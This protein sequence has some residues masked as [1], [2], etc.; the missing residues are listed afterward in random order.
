MNGKKFSDAMSELDEKYIHEA[1]QYQKKGKKSVWVRPVIAACLCIAFISIFFWKQSIVSTPESKHPIVTEEGITI[2]PLNVSLSS[3]VTADM[4]GFFLYQGRVY[5]Q[6]EWLTDSGNLVGDYLGTATGSIDEWTPQ[7]GYVDLAGSV[8][9]DFYS[10]KGFD[11]AFLLCMKYA[12]GQ[13]STYICN[14]GITL[15]Y[16]FE[17]FED[18]LHLSENCLSVTYETQESHNASKDEIH[19]LDLQGEERFKHFVRAINAAPFMRIQDIPLGEKETSIYDREIYRVYCNMQNG[20]TVELRLFEGGYVS[21]KG[22]RDICVHVPQEIF[23]SLI[24]SFKNET[25]NI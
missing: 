23:D 3:G 25:D 11:P 9:G 17:L 20:M 2:P 10:V 16:G 13:I 21:F 15:K 1:I 12:D 18:R 14:N 22:I 24:D 19:S 8:R 7:D 5:I 6:Y 4:V